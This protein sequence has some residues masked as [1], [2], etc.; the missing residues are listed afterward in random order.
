MRKVVNYEKSDSEKN[1]LYISKVDGIELQ[2]LQQRI[3]YL[4]IAVNKII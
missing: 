2:D 1:F 4:L 3:K